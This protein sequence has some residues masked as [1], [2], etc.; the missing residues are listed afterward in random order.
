MTSPTHL[1]MGVSL[2]AHTLT[3]TQTHTHTHTHTLTHTHTHTHSHACTHTHTHICTCRHTHMCIHTHFLKSDSE[4]S[5][6][7]LP[8]HKSFLLSLFQ[9]DTLK[10][11][12]FYKNVVLLFW[13]GG[14]GLYISFYNQ[15]ILSCAFYYIVKSCITVTE[16]VL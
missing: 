3:H 10:D 5:L 7:S 16:T 2:S 4:I 11:F 1:Q 12:W 8:W 13:G 14:G 15:I 6:N 9:K